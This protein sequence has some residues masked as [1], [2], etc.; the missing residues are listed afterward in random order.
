MERKA[1]PRDR[2]IE[3]LEQKDMSQKELANRMLL[4]GFL[5]IFPFPFAHLKMK[6][7]VNAIIIQVTMDWI[8]N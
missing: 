4:L 7:M 1:T 2:I 3:L 8:L 6:V 5:N